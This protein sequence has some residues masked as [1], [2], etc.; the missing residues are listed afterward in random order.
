MKISIISLSGCYGCLLALVETHEVFL[1]LFKKHELVYAPLLIESRKIGRSDITF[2]M[3]AVNSSSDK[4][5]IRQVRILSGK[6]VALG[7]CACLGGVIGLRNLYSVDE[8]LK[9]S[10]VEN[11]STAQPLIPEENVPSLETIVKPI[12]AFGFFVDYCLP[13]CPPNEGL[14]KKYIPEI[15]E[16]KKI[17]F[18]KYAVCKECSRKK[19]LEKLGGLAIKKPFKVDSS[20]CFLDQGIPC[21][22]LVTMAGCGAECPKGN[23]PCRGCM[24]AVSKNK[25]IMESAINTLSLIFDHTLSTVDNTIFLQFDLGGGKISYRLEKEV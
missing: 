17:D 11:V 10:F 1:D 6:I 9:K 8:I 7:T 2:V 21:L 4:K 18:P 15:L 16:F 14:L 13:G 5:L 19:D 24:G 20:L 3:G 25:T 12:E 22:G 23:M